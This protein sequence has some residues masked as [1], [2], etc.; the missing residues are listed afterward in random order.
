MCEQTQQQEHPQHEQ[1]DAQEEDESQRGT[2]RLLQRLPSGQVEAEHGYLLDKQQAAQAEDEDVLGHFVASPQHAGFEAGGLGLVFVQEQERLHWGGGA[3]GAL[4]VLGKGHG[5]V[6]GPSCVLQQG[7]EA[8]AAPPEEAH[9]SY[10]R[11][12][13]EGEGEGVTGGEG[14]EEV[15][16]TGEDAGPAPGGF[17]ELPVGGW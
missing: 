4:G 15:E 16:G 14:E 12:V 1:D 6:T 7:Q 11:E 3:R 9:E 17:K 2:G 10:T 8:P 5:F 13:A